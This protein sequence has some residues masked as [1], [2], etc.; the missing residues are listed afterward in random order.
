M[1]TELNDSVIEEYTNNVDMYNSLLTR[2]DPIIYFEIDYNVIA[3][4][5]EK[6]SQYKFN[7]SKI[8]VINTVS[9]KVTQT[10]SL[11]KIQPR[12]MKPEWDLREIEGIVH[13]EW[14]SL[15]KKYRTTNFDLNDIY[16]NLDKRLN[17]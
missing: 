8:R 13:D 10:S 9:G 4:R 6:P 5:D 16:N 17:T 7:F 1:E 2:G 15:I 11:N 12:T 3:E 14:I